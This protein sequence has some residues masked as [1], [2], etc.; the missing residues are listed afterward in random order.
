MSETPGLGGRLVGLHDAPDGT[1]DIIIE[2]PDGKQHLF[3][4][5]Y[6]T[7]R[8]TSFT[9]AHPDTI[10]MENVALLSDHNARLEFPQ[11]AVPLKMLHGVHEEI[12]PF[13]MREPKPRLRKCEECKGPGPCLSCPKTGRYLCRNCHPDH[14]DAFFDQAWKADEPNKNGDVFPPVGVLQTF[15]HIDK[16]PLYPSKILMTEG[17]YNVVTNGLTRRTCPD[18]TITTDEEVYANAWCD[19]GNTVCGFFPGYVLG[20]INPGVVLERRETRKDGR[21]TVVDSIRLSVL[22]A[23]CL[24]NRKEPPRQ[25]RED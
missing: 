12:V 23:N 2:S 16:K 14:N 22:A 18:G 3:T 20:A 7:K 19:L 15:E 21:Y 10:I 5:C 11:M 8:S 13:G 24:I 6:I 4:G 25:T 9:A 17:Y 1:L